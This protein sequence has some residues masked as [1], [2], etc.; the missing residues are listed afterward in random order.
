MDKETIRR[1]VDKMINLLEAKFQYIRDIQGDPI[2]DMED[3]R[4]L[5]LVVNAHGPVIYEMA[6]TIGVLSL[7]VEQLVDVR[8]ERRDDV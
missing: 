2:R 4:T 6:K 8:P 3:T 1:Q 5:A 7:A